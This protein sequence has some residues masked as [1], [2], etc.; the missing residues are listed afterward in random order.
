MNNDDEEIPVE[1]EEY[2]P[3][4]GKWAEEFKGLRPDLFF[5]ESWSQEEKEQVLEEIRPARMR[6]TMF[7]SIPMQCQAK[8]CPFANT[9]PLMKIHKAPKGYPCPLEMEIIHQFTIEL[10][11]EWQVDSGNLIEVAMIR[12]LVDQE[13]QYIRKAKVL[14][15]EHFIKENVV[16]VNE[17]TGEPIMVEGLHAAVDFEDRIHKRRRDIRKE[18]LMSREARVKVAQGE[19][20]T[21]KIMS[22]LL[23]QAKEVAD[24][25]EVAVRKK[26]GMSD[27]HDQY[28]EDDIAHR[29]SSEIIDAE[30]VE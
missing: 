16:G 17:K 27:L 7:S 24:A 19:V 20:D 9:C 5:P 4:K 15:N 23:E 1:I 26:L 6:N 10:M 25:K 14:G 29:E 13:V 28:I 11:E 12:D 3:D 8:A 18:M 22:K 30:E 2:D 21:S